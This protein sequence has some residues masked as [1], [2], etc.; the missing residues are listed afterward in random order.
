[1]IAITTGAPKNAV[2]VL[3]ES[4]VGIKSV[5][6]IRSQ[7]RQ[8]RAPP[9]KAAGMMT[10]GFAV[11]KSFFIRWGT[12]IPTKETGPAKAVTQADRREGRR[13]RRSL[14]RGISTPIE[15]ALVSPR[16]YALMG[17]ERRKARRRAMV[18][19][20][21]KKRALAIVVTEKLPR[22]QLCRFTM[23]ESF[24]KVMT[25]SVTAEQI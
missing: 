12:A 3:I 24:A 5:L 14:K 8:K 10:R 1:M 21:T 7:R 19:I 18:T 15:A 16:R 2:T 4:S 23:S 13:I 9:K 25:K 20:G 22:D 6:A 17:L 11:P